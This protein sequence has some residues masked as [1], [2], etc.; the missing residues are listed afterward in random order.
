MIAFRQLELQRGGEPLIEHADLILHDG[1]KVGIVGA[2][3]AGKSSLFKLILGELSADRGEVE[4]TSGSR[5]AH[6]AQEIDALDRSLV[7]YVLDGDAALREVERL[8]EAARASGD[9]L[10]QAEL[11]GQ[12]EVHD[13]YSAR[14]RAEQL[15]VGLGFSQQVLGHSLSAFSGGWRMRAN[16]ARTLFTP[17][18]LLLLDEPTN[19]L[20]LD[21][22]LWL[23]QWLIRYPGTLLLISH[24]RDFL[25]AVCDRIIHFDERRLE[26]YRGNYSAFERLRAERLASREAERAQQQAR[27]AELEDFVRRF[28]AKASKARQ[29]QSRL[30][31]LERMEEIAPLRA[32]S[33][34]S[35]RLLGSDKVS[36]PLLALD[37]ARVGYSDQGLLENVRLTLAPGDRIGLLGPNG[38]GKSTLIKALTGQ[39][40]LLDGERVEGEHLALG[41]FAQHQ[42]DA[43][44]MSSTPHQ[45]VLRLSPSA[46]DQEIRDFLGGFDFR[47]DAAFGRVGEFSGGEKARLALALIA[48]RRPN[49]LLLDE[50]TN[51]LDLEMRAAL[52]EA[53]AGFEGAVVIVSHD[54]HLL[55]ASVD[56]FWCVADG[57]VAPF[58]GDLDDYHAW[59]RQRLGEGSA[60]TPRDEDEAAP[61]VD[62]RELRRAAADRRE[63]LKPLTRARDTAERRMTELQNEIDALEARLG[64]ETL[65][66][67]ER[68]QELVELTRKRGE[69]AVALEAAEQGWLEAEE[70][71]ERASEE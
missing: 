40:A 48:W 57:R 44:D 55:R 4:L 10:R 22:L 29:A 60:K 27:R 18:D 65:Y 28:R 9:D 12:F 31:M 17:S 66:L 20:D 70:A 71:L 30:K 46:S 45:H 21:A 3:G 51:H 43:L 64:D 36:F 15:L 24:D 59:L 16:L 8:L 53:L 13:G 34:F 38:A 33:P 32:A 19:H 41:Y 47:G 23:E 35:F 42:V 2:N 26:L 5:I 56:Q 67:P 52:T 49:L 63:R 62:K 69:L 7:D 61:R 1:Q 6:M 14:A 50:P 39:L 54:R 68:K 11:L 58:D 25:D 37:R